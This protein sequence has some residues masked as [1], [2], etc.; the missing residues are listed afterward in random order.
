MLTALRRLFQTEHAWA[1][2]N[3]SA[4]LDEM[5]EG[6]Q[7]SRLERHLGECTACRA[8]MEG[9]RHTI[10]LLHLVP[11]L[12]LP[13]SFL[14]P[15]SEARPQVAPQRAWGFP[16]MRAAS[17]VASFLLVVAFSSN[18]AFRAGYLG[19]A[20][21]S[22]APP[23]VAMMREAESVMEAQAP[24]GTVTAEDSAKEMPV[25]RAVRVEK[26]VVQDTPPPQPSEAPVLL[27]KEATVGEGQEVAEKSRTEEPAALLEAPGIAASSKEAP[28]AT[29]EAMV[30]SEERAVEAADATPGET[31]AADAAIIAA[32]P[33]AQAMVEATPATMVVAERE[34]DTIANTQ[35]SEQSDRA[36]AR[37]SLG[38]VL[39][40]LMWALLLATV[41]LWAATA[42]FGRQ[43]R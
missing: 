23:Q 10:G 37:V 43:R 27:E 12:A 33:A 29:P 16:A 22:Q 2:D 28:E 24:P 17:V 21:A 40:G 18:L 20:P 11:E 7:R 32:T 34:F 38:A 1:R 8:E 39:D 31:V 36:R 26:E 19:G 6:G 4:Y 3:L 9:L 5:L 25:A 30:V 15:L 41:V 14:V 13:R 35:S 42:L